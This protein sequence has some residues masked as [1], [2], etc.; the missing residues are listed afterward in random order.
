GEGWAAAAPVE[1]SFT[2]LPDDD[3][4][5]IVNGTDNCPTTSNPGQG[6]FDEDGAG[7]ACDAD[8]D[9]DGVDDGDD[10]FPLDP[11]EWVDSD[12]DGVGDSA[13]TDDDGDGVDDG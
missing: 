4:D 1:S 10:A 12:G 8:D 9:N 7:D 3:G 6:D 5:G 2:I 11:G 13:D